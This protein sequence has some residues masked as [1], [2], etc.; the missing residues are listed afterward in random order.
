MTKPREQRLA[1]VAA[2]RQFDLT[3]VLENVWDPHNVAAILRSCDAVGVQE[4]HLV[5]T[6]E[7]FPGIG[8]KAA[9]GVK[10]WLT[11]TRHRSIT[12]CYR[13]L[14][15][16]KFIIY[17]SAVSPG[18][19]DLYRLNFRQPTA[20]VF[21]NEHRG[22]SEQARKSADGTFHIPMAGFARSLNVS[23][24]AAVALYEAYRQRHTNRSRRLTKRS[25]AL[26][27]R[28]KRAT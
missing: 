28:W 8:A 1:W 20:V 18:T 23:V 22:V 27:R 7:K 21:G 26:L 11:L 4:I 2:H 17:A 9:A 13:I 6:T 15:R 25:A 10:K 19:T 14:R 24:A 12:A 5:Y 16:R 3:V